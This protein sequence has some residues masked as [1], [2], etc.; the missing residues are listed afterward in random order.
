MIDTQVYSRGPWKV[1]PTL[2]D[3]LDKLF[4]TWFL[5]CFSLETKKIGRQAM[6]KNKT[7]VEH[8]PASFVVSGVTQP[9]GSIDWNLP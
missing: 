5:P 4:S 8:L 9:S 2:G 3:F 7:K 1:G 6:K